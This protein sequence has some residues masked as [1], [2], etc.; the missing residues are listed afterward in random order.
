MSRHTD[1]LK[2]AADA[3]SDGRD[4]FAADFL[5]EH[6]VTLDEVYDLSDLMAVG[7]RLVAWGLEHPE[8]AVAA[9]NG[10]RLQGAYEAL[11]GGLDKY[12]AGQSSATR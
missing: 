8:Q 9:L 1:L 3:L 7:A 11:R 2:T 5:V 12:L 6:E 4:P 10:A